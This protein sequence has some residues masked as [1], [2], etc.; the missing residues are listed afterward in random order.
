M[1]LSSN[2]LTVSDH[3]PIP[4]LLTLTPFLD[5]RGSFIKLY[6]PTISSQLC[7]S[8]APVESF[9]SFSQQS[10]FRGF[11]FQIPPYAHSKLVT[12]VSGAVI[13]FVLDLRKSSSTFGFV[14]QYSLCP[15]GTNTLF[16][17]QGY[18]HAFYAESPSLLIYNVDSEYHSDFDKGILWSSLNYSF[19][20]RFDPIISARDSSFPPF[21]S[22]DSPF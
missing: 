13:D 14:T 1:I 9:C 20:F 21:S 18:A 19:S 5:S 17:P 2:L 15:N 8:F 4:Q 3:F 10:V 6:S 7:S 22:F 11:H 16:I 12:C